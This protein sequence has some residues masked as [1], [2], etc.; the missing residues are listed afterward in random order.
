MKCLGLSRPSINEGSLLL[1]E[2]EMATCSSILAWKIPWTEVPGRLQSMGLQ[3][4]RYDWATEHADTLYYSCQSA[5]I[6]FNSGNAFECHQL[7]PQLTSNLAGKIKHLKKKPKQ[8]NYCYR[9]LVLPVLRDSEGGEHS[10]EREVVRE[11]F[12]EEETVTHYSI[13]A[14][15]ISWTEVPGRLQSMG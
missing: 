15:K 4:V 2:E 13:L 10:M 8:S 3:R 11:G 1:L 12:L 9:H 5:W 14:W 6:H 7:L